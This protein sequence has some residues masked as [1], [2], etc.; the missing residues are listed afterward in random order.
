MCFA[1]AEP[2]PSPQPA[3]NAAADQGEGA[4]NEDPH[5]V[6]VAVWWRRTCV[7]SD[8]SDWQQRLLP[9]GASSSPPRYPAVCVASHPPTH[10]RSGLDNAGKTTILKRFNGED[11]SSISPTLGFNIQTLEHR[12]YK[13]NIWD[14]GGQATIR[15]YWRNYFEATDG[16]VWVV[17]CADA[18]RLGDCGAALGALLGQEKLAGASL[19]ILANKQDLPGALGPD[20]VARALG[21]GGPAFEGR[22]WAIVCCSAV[23]GDGLVSGMDWLVD[24]VAGKG[25]AP[26]PVG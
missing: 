1:V 22:H 21:L 16:L 4:R 9:L 12:G 23:M 13:L 18:A 15:A 26:P 8:E 3:H 10:P 17:D 11:T 5:P 7:S 20:G 19:L 25:G 14:V 24:D 2:T 6:R